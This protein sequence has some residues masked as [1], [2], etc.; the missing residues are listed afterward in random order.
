MGSAKGATIPLALAVAVACSAWMAACRPAAAQLLIPGVPAGRGG[1]AADSD[2][3]S[4]NVFLPA[5]RNILK[6]MS[7]AKALLEAGRHGEAVGLLGNILRDAEDGGCVDYFFQPDKNSKRQPSLKSEAQRL[8]GGM[9]RAARELYELQFGTEARQTLDSAIATGDNELLT[10][11][12]RCYFHTRA[13]GDATFLLGLHNMDRAHQLSGA[14]LLQR[15]RDTHHDANRFEP[16]LSLTLATGWLQAGMPENARQTLSALKRS[17][18]DTEVTVAGK[19]VPLFKVDVE[20]A[21][22]LAGLIGPQPS[23]SERSRHM[24]AWRMFRGSAARNATTD[25]S[26]PLL[27]VRWHIPLTHELMIREMLNQ[28][29]RVNDERGMATLSGLHPLAV[30]DVVLM[31]TWK[32]IMAMDFK[33]GK[34]LWDYPVDMPSA[35]PTGNSSADMRAKTN[36]AGQLGQRMWDDSVFGKLSSDGVR[37]FSVEG[38][39]SQPTSRHPNMIV[40]GPQG[41]RQAAQPHN[42]LV[43][44]DIKT[45]KVKWHLGGENG[46]RAYKE[47]GT[48]FLGPP[49][50]LQGKLYVLGEVG[51]EIN[52]FELE[53]ATGKVLRRQPLSMVE[54]NIYVDSQR[55]LAGAMP[56]YADGVLVCPISNG[57]VVA[58]DLATQSLLWGYRYAKVDPYRRYTMP[59]MRLAQLTGTGE[60][61]SWIDFTATISDG[62]V[63]ITPVGSN[64]VHCLDLL[65]GTLQWKA[66]RGEDLYVGCVHEGKVVLVGRRQLRALKISDGEPAWDGRAV[67]L[68][69]GG[70]PSGRGFAGQKRYFVPLD[71]AEVAVVNLEE[72]KLESVAKSRKGNVP[73]NMICYQGCVIS[74]GTDG[75]SCFYQLDMAGK[76]V[77]ETLA[78]NPDD[79]AALALRGEILLDQADSEKGIISLF[80][81]LELE[82]SPRTKETLTD[83][84]IAGLDND[85]PTHRKYAERLE[86]LIETTGRK[87]TYLRLMAAGFRKTNQWKSALEKY[88][89][90]I[91]F[92]GDPRLGSP[93]EGENIGPEQMA[94]ML[95]SGGSLRDGNDLSFEQISKAYTLRRDRWVRADLLALRNEMPD[96]EKT[97]LDSVVGKRREEVL[98]SNEQ[99][100]SRHFL[101]YFD[102]Q[103]GSDRVRDQLVALLDKGGE[104]LAAELLSGRHKKAETVVDEK[105][106]WP[107]KVVD[108]QQKTSNRNVSGFQRWIMAF[109]GNSEPFFTDSSIR[110][111]R[112]RSQVS[113]VDSLGKDRWTL[114]LPRTSGQNYYPYMSPSSGIRANGHLLVMKLG[115]Q[116]VAIDTLG[117]D[118]DGPGGK[119]PGPRLLW[120]E[121]LAKLETSSGNM[122][123]MLQ[124]A[125][126]LPF[127]HTRMASANTFDGLGPVTDAYTCFQRY[128]NL[129][130][131]DTASGKQIWTRRDVPAGCALFGDDEY[132]FALPPGEEEAAVYRALDGVFLGTRPVRLFMSLDD[133]TNPF[134]INAAAAG[135]A[136]NQDAAPEKSDETV[137]VATPLPFHATCKA[138]IGRN[139]LS[140]Y[141]SEDGK[142][143]T[144]ELFDPWEQKLV[145]KSRQFSSDAK[146]SISED[147]VAVVVE[148][149]GKL[150]MI[151]LEDG[152][153]IAEHELKIDKELTGLAFLR[154][155]DQFILMLRVKD[156]RPKGVQVTPLS[157]MGPA[158]ISSGDVYLIDSDGR[159]VWDKPAVIEHQ[160]LLSNQ[161]SNLP[162]ITFACRVYDQT[163]TSNKRN[164]VSVLCLDRRTGKEAYKGNVPYS[165][166]SIEISGDAEDKTVTLNMHRS[167]ILLKY[168]DNPASPSKT[169]KADL[170]ANDPVPNI[171]ATEAYQSRFIPPRNDPPP[172]VPVPVKK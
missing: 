6:S 62:R 27:N 12:S 83:A 169:D 116:V 163:K 71:S 4:G 152:R 143:Y 11:V 128:R 45:G 133:G 98:R 120:Q 170:K 105:V 63:L 154:S 74:Q 151:A 9:P 31:R 57:A 93:N 132:V 15:L 79:P 168:S 10:K 139:L 85:F 1:T 167:S 157:G 29:K 137:D 125:I 141:P 126:R 24:D 150:A 164:T 162:V 39:P 66:D 64:S 99:L 135:D 149:N 147:S 131:V 160:S 144:L 68:P 145:W 28:L 159:L 8:I 166:N 129:V 26:A 96:S 127:F 47:A 65:D 92:D 89:E 21:D 101:D 86:K 40:A 102:G 94:K 72:G 146:I 2:D 138:T 50:P 161:P 113:C 88:V 67:K 153:M 165:Y 106:V 51:D 14:L 156:D 20:A 38:L 16:N 155:G 91:D 69:A 54:R 30:N 158:V 59:N 142:H 5:D 19:Q 37:V 75:L 130:A 44:H 103:P 110:F 84:L 41:T 121:D 100:L 43:A 13:G 112:G 119:E 55:R 25:S 49:L 7:R 36:L 61:S 117:K 172:A 34:R 82:E 23:A 46:E 77:K 56:S 111:D 104:P 95:D 53:A 109:R 76:K 3:P 78:A 81:S 108:S 87:A 35:K 52:L 97:E 58:L 18:P 42:L 17:H 115:N 48:F 118:E 32:T 33:T 140:W 123:G 122:G 136:G 70:M 107:P 148:P 60:T 90:L 73:G 124:Q 134:A 114:A 80:R 22:W 171:T